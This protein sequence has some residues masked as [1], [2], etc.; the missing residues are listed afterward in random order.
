MKNTHPLLHRLLF[1]FFLLIGCM[2]AGYAQRATSVTLGAGLP[3]LINL[4]VRQQFDQFQA[5]V[6]VGIFPVTDEQVYTIGGDVYLHFGNPSDYSDL[7]PWYGRAGFTYLSDKFKDE[8]DEY[9]YLNL[10]IGRD[11]NT[12]EN[13]GLFAELGA[14]VELFYRETDTEP[15]GWFDFDL[16]LAPVLP[17]FGVGIYWRF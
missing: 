5:G 8:R 11:F 15:T 10:R 3:E 7:R 6:F 1:T 4:G 17:G 9:G 14:M 13:F 12:S 16:D 2:I